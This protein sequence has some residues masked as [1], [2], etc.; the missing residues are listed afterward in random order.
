MKRHR[1]LRVEGLESRA[2]L[3]GNITAYVDGGT[4]FVRGDDAGNGVSIQQLDNNRYAVIGFDVAGGA[5]RVNGSASAKAFSGVVNDINI[6]L[7]GGDDSLVI[8]NK[9]TVND[10]LAAEVSATTPGTITN[11]FTVNNNTVTDKWVR[12]PR[13]LIVHT[14]DGHDGVGLQVQ[15][16]RPDF[17]GV[18]NIHTHDGNDRVALQVVSAED[19]VLVNTGHGNDRVRMGSVNAYDFVFANLGSGNDSLQSNYLRAGHSHMLGGDGNDA[20]AVA[21]SQVRRE[22]LLTGDA[23]NDTIRLN[24]GYAQDVTITTA[25]GSDRVFAANFRVHDD[26]VIDTGAHRD[27]V[28]TDNLTVDDHFLVVLGAG[29]DRFNNS[30]SRARRATFDG[31]SDFDTYN[32]GGGN[33][34]DTDVV[35]FENRIVT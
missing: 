24:G 30:N 14:D 32:N 15:A 4:L 9:A 13:N 17:G 11:P 33:S 8:A 6:D 2:M 10:S 18:V 29:D 28:T 5:T 12:V 26:L 1:G 7:N 34:G 27:I 25:S 22:L 3:A 19:D 31:G 23:G 21:N 35:N 20:M 16:G